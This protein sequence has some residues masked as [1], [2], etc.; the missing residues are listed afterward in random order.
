MVARQGIAFE[1]VPDRS[2][3]YLAPENLALNGN[4]VAKP[5]EHSFPSY[6]GLPWCQRS[7]EMF[8]PS[9]R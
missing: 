4:L 1:P 5:A 6:A 2:V 7:C 9:L 3:L 8:S